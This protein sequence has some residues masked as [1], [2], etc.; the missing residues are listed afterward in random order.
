MLELSREIGAER[1]VRQH[2]LLQVLYRFLD[3]VEMGGDGTQSAIDL[4][5]EHYPELLRP[6]ADD[7]LARFEDNE[8]MQI[9]RDMLKT[10]REEID[11]RQVR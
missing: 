8:L 7:L 1:A 9:L 5:E 3:E 6:E 11:A 2:A 4:A 10:R